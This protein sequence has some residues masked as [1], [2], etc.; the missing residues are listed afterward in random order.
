MSEVQNELQVAVTPT[1]S[2]VAKIE[3]KKP[4][5]VSISIKIY[6]ISDINCVEATFQASFK[7]F[8]RWEDPKLVG[9]KEGYLKQGAEEG[10][11]E[12]PG[13]F[14]PDIQ[15]TN[16]FE[17][18][19]TGRELRVLDSSTGRVKLS[20]AYKGKLFMMEMG[21]KFFP[22]DAQNLQ[23]ILKPHKLEEQKV[24]L[25][26]SSDES[27]SDFHP[28]HEWR[29]VGF[30]A[31]HYRTD[32]NTS[33]TN[34]IYSSLHIV[35]CVQRESGWFINNI[36]IPTFVLTMVAWATFGLYPTGQYAV[37]MN[38]SVGTILATIENKFAAGDSLSK[39]PYRSMVDLYIDMSF[40]CQ[41]I[42]VIST[43]LVFMYA[44][45]RAYAREEHEV[46]GEYFC[47]LFVCCLCVFFLTI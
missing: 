29:F 37:R 10:E 43:A 47:L 27:A 6:S 40:I 32:P 44:T 22:F 31:K 21:L 24:V 38:A 15:V 17:L 25:R 12:V 9:Q 33:T 28:V 14:N 4:K 30:C 2:S 1:I 26:Y 20:V 34:K 7:L 36:I 5:L 13:I 8:M 41:A 39:V 3:K 45:P 18:E 16:E 19:E 11:Y 46:V 23:I 42:A 35:I